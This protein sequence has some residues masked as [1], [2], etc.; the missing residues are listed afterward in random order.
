VYSLTAKLLSYQ[1]CALEPIHY[2]HIA[3]HKYKFVVRP[4]AQALAGFPV[5][6]F[7]S[8]HNFIDSLLSVKGLICVH[9]EGGFYNSLQGHYVE[10]VVINYKN[11]ISFLATTLEMRD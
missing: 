4:F 7:C 3:V 8:L 10:D 2:W 5:I 1:L 11:F 9:L 6:F